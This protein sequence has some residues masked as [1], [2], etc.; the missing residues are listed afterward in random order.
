MAVPFMQ[1]EEFGEGFTG[2]DSIMSTETADEERRTMEPSYLGSGAFGI[3]TNLPSGLVGKY[4]DETSEAELARQVK[5]NPIPCIVNV[6]SVRQAQVYPEIF[7]I[8][9]DKV[10]VLYGIER[11]VISKLRTQIYKRGHGYSPRWKV[12]TKVKEMKN[13]YIDHIKL[14][15]DYIGLQQCLEANDIL[16][17]DAHGKNIGYDKQG[18]LVLFDLG[19]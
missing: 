1:P 17:D 2:I 15:D 11:T 14:I 6:Y 7:M 18:N 10:K 4:T 12:P 3:A 9:M 16:G 13:R 19:T 5:D 8:I